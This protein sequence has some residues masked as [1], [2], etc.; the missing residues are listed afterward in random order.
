MT[1]IDVIKQFNRCQHFIKIVKKMC[2]AQ[3]M[4]LKALK[5][6]KKARNVKKIH[7]Q[8]RKKPE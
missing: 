1:K 8:K 6:V 4:N 5:M 3:K 7:T 2:Q